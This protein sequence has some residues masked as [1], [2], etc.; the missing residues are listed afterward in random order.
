MRHDTRHLKKIPKSR[1]YSENKQL[2]KGSERLSNLP[3]VIHFTNRGRVQSQVGQVQG[4]ALMLLFVMG[5]PTPHLTSKAVCQG[6]S[7][8]SDILVF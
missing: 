1:A 7:S 5:P 3:E 8:Y 6:A 2:R 4:Q